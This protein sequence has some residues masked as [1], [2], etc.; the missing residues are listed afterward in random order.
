MYVD[1]T[2]Q[3]NSTEIVSSVSSIT[4]SDSDLIISNIG[5]LSSGLNTEDGHYLPSGQ[6][7]YFSATCTA[8]KTSLACV[9]ITYLTNLSHSDSTR[10]KVKIV[11]V[12]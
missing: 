2:N 4:S 1:C 9:D 5:I 8:N 6:T 10:V 7:I 12:I 11:E 3:L